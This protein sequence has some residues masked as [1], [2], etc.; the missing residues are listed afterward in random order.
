MVDLTKLPIGTRLKT[1]DGRAARL[2]ANDVK[3]LVPCVIAVAVGP[4]MEQ[5]H[6]VDADGVISEGSEHP[7]DIVGIERPKHRVRVRVAREGDAL[8]ARAD[9]EQEMDFSID[10]GG[11]FIDQIVE[12]EEADRA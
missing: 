6:S 11:F 8:I 1:R 2:L 12:L 3:G 9:H 7:H 5:L 10:L 4:D